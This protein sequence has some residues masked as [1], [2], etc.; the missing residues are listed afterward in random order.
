[1]QAYRVKKKVS[2][3]GNIQLE[4]LPFAKGEIVE[5]IVLAT[6]EA[7]KT[8]DDAIKSTTRSLKGSV[9]EYVNPTAP[10]AQ[11]EWISAQ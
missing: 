8:E 4:A 5:I 1:M 10:V 9:L 11:D 6:S 7:E 2:E 3:H